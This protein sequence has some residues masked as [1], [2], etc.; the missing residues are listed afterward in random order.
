VRPQYGSEHQRARRAA[1]AAFKDGDMC[2]RCRR[3][4]RSWQA[5][6][7]DHVRAV[8]HGGSDGPKRLAHARC[9]RAA[10]AVIGNRS[11]R[12]RVKRRAQHRE[13]PKW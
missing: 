9:N 8:A 3:P 10:G 5:L 2:W 12:R 1:L 11:A 7:L 6:D 4:M 13:L